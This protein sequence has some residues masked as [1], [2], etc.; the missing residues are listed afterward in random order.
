MDEGRGACQPAADQQPRDS[1]NQLRILPM[2]PPGDCSSAHVWGCRAGAT[3]RGHRIERSP[4][5]SRVLTSEIPTISVD[6]GAYRACRRSRSWLWGPRR[7]ARRRCVL[8]PRAAALV[9][10]LA[11]Q[12]DRAPSLGRSPTSSPSTRTAWAARSDTSPPSA[13]G[14]DHLGVLVSRLSPDSLT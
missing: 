10:V 3:G 4:A 9:L 14:T 13:S 5:R 11:A 6:R 7:R 2:P 1:C 8:L 12:I